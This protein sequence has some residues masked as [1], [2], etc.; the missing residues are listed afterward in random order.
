MKIKLLSHL[1]WIICTVCILQTANPAIADIFLDQNKKFRITADVRLRYE[2]DF[3]TFAADG[4]ER[5]NRDRLRLRVRFGLTYMPTETISLVTRF[6]TGSD[7]NQQSPHITL[8]DFDDNP[9][10]NKD[11][12]FDIWYLKWSQ[13]NTSVWAGRNGSSFWRQN[14]MLLDDDISM[15][16]AFLNQK[17]KNDSGNYD[18]NVAYTYLPDGVYRLHGN[19]L[20]S[21]FVY[22][23]NFSKTQFTA[24]GGLFWFAGREGAENLRNNNGARDY[25]IWQGS[26][27][28]KWDV[29]KMPLKLGA[30]FL[31]NSKDYS[32]DD[33]FGFANRNQNSGYVFQIEYG[34]LSKRN[35]WLV[36]FYYSH[37]ETLAVNASYAQDDWWR[38][39]SS[40]QTDSSD[41]E[42]FEIRA[43]F[44]PFQNHN[45][46]MRF[47]DVDGIVSPQKGKRF[48]I[49]Y[50]VKF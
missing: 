42:G 41:Y 25:L 48:R 33:P 17:W 31:Y 11:L 44:S 26:L 37:I 34:Q 21:Q 36:G 16:G 24:A 3:D 5:P 12:L 8:H 43:G 38:F 14:E 35:Q 45:I 7:R 28:G 2:R 29:A 10:G 40:D 30:D 46:L 18:L 47:Y 49:D 13:G 50:N 1:C 39:G 6:R 22:G 15:V 19:L 20:G 32:M 27:Q 9:T 4:S 23:K